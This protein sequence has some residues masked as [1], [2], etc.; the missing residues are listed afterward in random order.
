[1]VALLQRRDTACRISE[2]CPHARAGSFG[3][4]AASAD[5]A[6]FSRIIGAPATSVR[7]EIFGRLV[8]R[9]GCQDPGDQRGQRQKSSFP[10]CASPARC[11][12][13]QRR[14]FMSRCLEEKTL[15]LLS[16]GDGG[17]E[18]RSHLQNCRPCMARYDDLTRDLRSI[19]RTLQEEPPPLRAGNPRA[20]IL[21]RS[22]AIAAGL[23]LAI[24]LV[25]GER[26]AW[27]VSRSV[28]EQVLNSE[29]SQF[30]E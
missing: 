21:Y 7:F 26:W 17:A 20:A 10:G 16:E 9:R 15:L 4:R 6:R 25:W 27:R 1:M 8:H 13:E 14:R 11:P 22:V 19:T 24:A 12:Q 18:K 23:L 30:L 3:A 28:S 2:F 5:L 29:I